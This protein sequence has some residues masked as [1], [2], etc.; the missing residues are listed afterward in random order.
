[1][2]RFSSGYHENNGTD[3]TDNNV[4]VVL[5]AFKYLLSRAHA[6]ASTHLLAYRYAGRHF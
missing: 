3:G 5:R 1:M 4:H 2:F 6:H